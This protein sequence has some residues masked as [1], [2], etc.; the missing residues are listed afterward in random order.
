M[1]VPTLIRL[2]WRFYT[3]HLERGLPT[4]AEHERSNARHVWVRADDPALPELLDDARYYADPHGPDG[5]GMDAAWY[6]GLKASAKATVA[7][8]EAV[9]KQRDALG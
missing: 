3:D 7:A 9:L 1:N 2:P 5:G 6:R 4:P 8:I